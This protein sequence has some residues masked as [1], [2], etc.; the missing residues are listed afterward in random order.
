MKN[1]VVEAIG[2]FFLVLVI[3]LSVNFGVALAPLAI[4]ATLMVMA[5]S[6]GHMSGAHFNPAISLAAVIRGSLPAKHL[7]GY[8][9][10]QLIGALAAAFLVVYLTG[11]PLHVAPAATADWLQVLTGEFVFTFALA[12]VVLNTSTAKGTSGN[13]FYGLAIGATVMAGAFTLGNLTGGAFNPAV[14]LAPALV[15]VLHGL[16]VTAEWWIY[17]VGPVLGASFAAAMFRWLKA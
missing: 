16:P 5:Y 13:S 17:L 8:W 1:Y 3:G 14:G 7:A 4:G 10:A 11:K 12:W 6:C 9:V 15:E 2:T